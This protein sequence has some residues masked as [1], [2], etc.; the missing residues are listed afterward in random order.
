MEAVAG[1]E[2]KYVLKWLGVVIALAVFGTVLYFIIVARFTPSWVLGE[3]IE[4]PK[5]AIEIHEADVAVYPNLE[6]FIKNITRNTS[7]GEKGVQVLI[8]GTNG[9]GRRLENF[10]DTRLAVSNSTY[11]YVI[12]YGDKYYGLDIIFQSKSPWVLGITKDE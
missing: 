8:K 11:P 7:N 4:D 10:L 9:D 6:K 2:K 5:Q 1:G 3:Q 12:K